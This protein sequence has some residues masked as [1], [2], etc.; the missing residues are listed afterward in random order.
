MNAVRVERRETTGT[1]RSQGGFLEDMRL[2]FCSSFADT[3]SVHRRWGKETFPE[4]QVDSDR[5]DGVT[6][7][8]TL[9]CYITSHS[10]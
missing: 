4:W 1:W 5:F 10:D 7:G 9:S 8:R 3:D 2:S 6:Q